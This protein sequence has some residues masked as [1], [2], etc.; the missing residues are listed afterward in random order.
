MNNYP[1]FLKTVMENN[2]QFAKAA[3]E[4]A[5]AFGKVRTIVMADGA[6]SQKFK[7]IIAIAI[8]VSI[9]CDEC[10]ADHVKEAISQGMTRDELVDAMKVAFAMGGGGTHAWA[11]KALAAFDQFSAVK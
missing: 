10:L 9:R 7:S 2:E 3:H 4:A 1:Q 5:Q 6:I 11:A 8:S